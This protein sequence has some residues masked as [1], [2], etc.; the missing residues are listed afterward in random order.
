MS[1]HQDAAA[2]MLSGME[3]LKRPIMQAIIAWLALPEGSRSL[4]VSAQ[5]AD[6]QSPGKRIISEGKG[7][8]Q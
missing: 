4:D 2:K 8:I 6:P 3:P 5:R 7:R 1:I